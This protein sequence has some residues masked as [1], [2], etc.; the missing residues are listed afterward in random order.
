[1]LLPLVLIALVP[2]I[3][4]TIGRVVLILLGLDLLAV[5][6]ALFRIL[7]LVAVRENHVLFDHILLDHR[8]CAAARSLA[9][10]ANTHSLPV[11]PCHHPPLGVPPGR[12]PIL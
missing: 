7:L 5:V 9:A 6:T 3:T 8:G 4:Q 2:I 10:G 1:R 11:C 12:I